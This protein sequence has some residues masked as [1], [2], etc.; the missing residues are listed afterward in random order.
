VRTLQQTFLLQI[1][2]VL[3]HR[4]QRLETQAASDLLKGRG[5][6]VALH[7]IADEV[8]YFFLP[9]SYRHPRII[10]NKKR[11]KKK[12]FFLARRGSIRALTQDMRASVSFWVNIGAAIPL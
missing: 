12:T 11:I 3:V 9:A 1:C 7:E 10:G 4:G 6:T 5:V 8:E 2:N